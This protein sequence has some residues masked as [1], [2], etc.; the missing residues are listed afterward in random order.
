MSFGVDD[1]IIMG[2]QSPI[3]DRRLFSMVGWA[4]RCLL[5]M[6]GL[7][8]RYLLPM[9]LPR[10]I[11]LSVLHQILHVRCE[12]VCDV[13]CALKFMNSHPIRLLFPRLWVGR[14]APRCTRLGPKFP[15]ECCLHPGRATI[16][17]PPRLFSRSC[18]L[19]VGWSFCISYFARGTNSPS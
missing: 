18:L 7:G 13:C 4:N 10:S 11:H 5:H 12:S 8:S 19:P 9:A 1:H 6:V 17:L 15:P 3:T 14:F 2:W 16:A